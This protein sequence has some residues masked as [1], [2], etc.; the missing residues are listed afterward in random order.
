MTQ[1]KT[2][3]NALKLIMLSPLWSKWANS[4]PLETMFSCTNYEFLIPIHENDF[5]RQIFW[6]KNPKDK[7]NTLEMAEV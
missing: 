5:E 7:T 4:V 6:C 3:K 1:T 2:H